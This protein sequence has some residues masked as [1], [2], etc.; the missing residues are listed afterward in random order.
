M[1][2]EAELFAGETS[3]PWLAIGVGGAADEAPP[4]VDMVSEL[5]GWLR[6]F[7]T[8]RIKSLQKNLEHETGYR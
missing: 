7:G 4:G 3:E 8:V 2:E 1:N 6:K 5:V